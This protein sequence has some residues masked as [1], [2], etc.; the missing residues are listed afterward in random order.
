[1]RLGITLT[2]LLAAFAVVGCDRSSGGS[3][4]PPSEDGAPGTF[5]NCVGQKMV[6]IARAAPVTFQMGSKFSTEEVARRY[7][8][9]SRYFTDEHPRHA[10]TLSKP[11]YMAN[12]EVTVGQFRRF[13]QATGYQ[14]DAEKGGQDFENGRK[15]GYTVQSDGSWGWREDASWKNPGFAQTDDHPVVLVSWND[16]QAYVQWLNEQAR[17]A[18]EGVTYR[19]PSEAEWEYACR[20][21]TTTAF[22]WSDEP[23]KSGK[24][25]NVAD[26]AAKR[27]YSGWTIM[28]MDDGAV[29]TAPVGSYRSNGYGLDDMIGNVWEWCGDWYEAYPNSTAESEW[30]GRKCRVLRGGSWDNDPAGCRC[31]YRG[32]G[33]PADRSDCIGFR[34]A[35]GTQ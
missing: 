12:T 19:L 23:D 7:G 26:R 4:S 1:M 21:G 27:K 30:F 17:A 29:Y 25:A 32:R 18:G 16:A 33:R 14:T 34:V 2:A 6:L 11:Y 15:G 3:G 35:A 8:G 28:E 24:V 20:G 5:V 13:V 31:A 10:V 22:W 9:E